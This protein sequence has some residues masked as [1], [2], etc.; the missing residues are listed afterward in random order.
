MKLISSDICQ[1]LSSRLDASGITMGMTSIEYILF[2]RF[3]LR[4]GNVS[5]TTYT[6]NENYRVTMVNICVGISRSISRN[7]YEIKKRLFIYY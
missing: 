5:L 3:H 6:N 1:A 7:I 2:G 4:L